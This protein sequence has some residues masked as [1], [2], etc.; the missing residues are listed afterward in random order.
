MDYGEIDFENLPKERERAFIYLEQKF[1]D[2]YA[3]SSEIDRGK[4]RGRDGE[5]VGIFEPART[6]ISSI[7]A[8]C[9]VLNLH[10][11]VPDISDF[12]MSDSEKFMMEFAAFKLKIHRSIVKF[13]LRLH[14]GQA[15]LHSNSIGRVIVIRSDYK[16]EI[17]KL[18]GT[19]RKIVNQEIKDAR[20]K[21]NIFRKISSLHSEV[22]RDQTTVD[23]LFGLALDLT[24]TIG[25][26]AENLDPLLEKMEKLK[27]LFWDG[28]NQADALSDQQHPQLVETQTDESHDEVPH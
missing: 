15:L 14:L 21:E 13:N 17:G 20:K 12:S 27:R 5:Y 28:S 1:R 4:N 23:S 16:D 26:C 11:D 22:D 25:E 10:I 3:R 9:E 6:Y 2:I 8:I 18:L 7:V 19:I 24:K